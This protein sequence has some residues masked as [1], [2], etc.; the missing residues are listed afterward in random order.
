MSLRALHIVFISASIALSV[1]FGLW[2]MGIARQSGAVLDW[3]LAILSGL[4]AL[5][6]MVYLAWFIRKIK[7][8]KN[9]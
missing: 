4:V 2:Q 5:A 6:L 7:A 1:I 9:L 3:F 8:V